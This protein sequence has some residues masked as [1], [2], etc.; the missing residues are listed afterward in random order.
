MSDTGWHYWLFEGEEGHLPLPLEGV[1]PS[2]FTSMDAALTAARQVG[3]T[4]DIYRTP[5][6]GGV[7]EFVQTFKVAHGSVKIV[8]KSTITVK[9]KKTESKDLSSRWNIAAPAGA[10]VRKLVFHPPTDKGN[11]WRVEALNDQD[12]VLGS[13]MGDPEDA[14]LELW[15]E[16]K[17]SDE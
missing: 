16:V 10:H 9:G 5:S 11:P 1:K 17:P 13:G 3:R 8:A 12:E 6:R 7:A 2:V 4:V 15:E 14:Y